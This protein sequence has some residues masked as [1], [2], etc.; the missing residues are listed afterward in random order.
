MFEVFLDTVKNIILTSG[1]LNITWQQILMILISCVLIYLAIGKQFEPLLLLPI[2]FGMLLTNIP[3]AGL[4]HPEFF[5]GKTVDFAGIFSKKGLIDFLYLGVKL[6]I[7]PP[8]IF[9]GIGAMTDFTPL[10]SNPKSVCL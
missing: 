5:A 6:G 10:I 8:I 3:I 1:F 7:Y 4:Y 9:L 2:A